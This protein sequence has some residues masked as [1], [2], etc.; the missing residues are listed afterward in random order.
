MIGCTTAF[1]L[2]PPLRGGFP[3]SD[4]LSRR[5]GVAGVTQEAS[6]R[7]TALITSVPDEEVNRVTVHP[8]R[9]FRISKPPTSQAQLVCVLAGTFS[10]NNPLIAVGDDGLG[11]VWGSRWP[12][13]MYAPCA[14]L[15]PGDSTCDSDFPLSTPGF[16]RPPESFVMR[17]NSGGVCSTRFWPTWT[18]FVKEHLK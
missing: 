16:R 11:G 14:P 15:T 12:S 17:P 6:P 10:D 4:P 3:R 18:F 1:R 5:Q 8:P 7:G 9:S 2:V 13:G